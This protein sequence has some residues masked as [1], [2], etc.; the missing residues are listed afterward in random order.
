VP[1]LIASW[2][3]E[4]TADGIQRDED[5]SRSSAHGGHNAKT[6]DRAIIITLT[7]ALA[8]FAVGKFILEHDRDATR[9]RTVAE[10][11]RDNPL[12]DADGDRPIAVL[13]LA[14]MSSSPG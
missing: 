11:A 8:Y 5:V 14:N 12:I 13:P 7:L 6:M 3:F 4:V 9:E 2:L 10:Q 1:A